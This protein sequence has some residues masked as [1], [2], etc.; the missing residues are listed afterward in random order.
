M[1]TTLGDS[2]TTVLQRVNLSPGVTAHKDQARKYLSRLGAEV[3]PLVPWLFLNRTTTFR[4]TQTLTITGASGTFTVG[5]TITGTTSTDTAVVD[6]HDT[7]NS[8][9]YVYS[10]SGALTATE[11]ITGATSLVTATY[12]SAAYTRV[13]TPVSGPITNWVSFTDETN[14]QPLGFIGR[15]QYDA[16]DPARSD[17]GT[18]YDVMVGGLNADTGYPEIELWYTPSTTNTTIRVRYQMDIAAWASTDD[19]TTLQV[20]GIPRQLEAVLEHGAMELYL[21]EK[22]HYQAASEERA[23]KKRA[24]ESATTQNARM[25]GNRRYPRRQYEGGADLVIQIGTDVVSA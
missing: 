15:D 14:E 23:N 8:L 4:T 16:L 25:Q 7:T 18:A 24:M 12:A 10:E 5:E 20:L 21:Q 22:R 13:Y 3:Y 9:L 6:H 1:A 19:A 2:I 17:T 11:T